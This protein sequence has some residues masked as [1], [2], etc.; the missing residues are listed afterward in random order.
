MSF[1]I[2]LTNCLAA[3]YFNC[4]TLVKSGGFGMVIFN[5]YTQ[6]KIV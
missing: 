2:M 5:F 3:Y 6:K 4:K 1:F